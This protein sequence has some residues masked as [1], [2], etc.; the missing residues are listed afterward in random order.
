[1]MYR[2]SRQDVT[3]L[4]VNRKINVRFGYRHNV[5]AMVDRL[6]KVRLYKYPRSSTARILGL[7][8]GG[9]SVL[10]KFIVTNRREISGF[11]APGL[12]NPVVVL[13]DNDSGAGNVRS[14]IKDMSKLQVTGA[15]PFVHVVK[16]L[17]ALPTPLG[18]AKESHI[19]DFFDAA[20]KG[21]V[22]G[23]KTFNETNKTDSDKHYGKTVFAHRV[24]R[25]HADTID[26]SGFK[27][28]LTNLV[29]AI[30]QHKAPL[31]V[32]PSAP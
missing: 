26:F 3:G 2:T 24:V 17:Y 28:L 25:P 13:Y 6:L 15:E 29:A 31:V 30:K 18:G 14:T 23:G 22:I 1:M 27:P 4:V 32:Q 8:D 20:I 7:Q 5:R 21:T 10:S 16:N 19:E 9:S 11:T 12:A